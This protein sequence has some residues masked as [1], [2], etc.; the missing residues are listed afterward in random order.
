LRCRC[1]RSCGDA[2][3]GPVELPDESLRLRDLAAAPAPGP[4]SVALTISFAASLALRVG[5]VVALI[6]FER[7]ARLAPLTA[8]ARAGPAGAAADGQRTFA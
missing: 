5:S 2:V 3:G 8:A 6:A 1:G 4:R 7:R